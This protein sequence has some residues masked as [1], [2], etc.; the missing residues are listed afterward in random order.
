MDE[1]TAFPETPV[2]ELEPPPGQYLASEKLANSTSRPW[3]K[4]VR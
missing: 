3:T 1:G 4:R 2:H